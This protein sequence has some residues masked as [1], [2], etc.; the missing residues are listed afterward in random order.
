M[1]GAAGQ[2]RAREGRERQGKEEVRAERGRGKKV[3]RGSES[4]FR[5]GGLKRTISDRLWW[6]QMTL[7]RPLLAA[8]RF[9]PAPKPHSLVV[10]PYSGAPAVY[11][12]SRRKYGEIAVLNMYEDAYLEGGLRVH[13]GES[14]HPW[15]GHLFFPKGLSFNF[16]DLTHIWES[17][18]CAPK[19]RYMALVWSF[20]AN[21]LT[22]AVLLH[23]QPGFLSIDCGIAE[24]L[25]YTDDKNQMF[26]TS[27]AKFID[28][29]TNKD[30]SKDYM[31]Q[32]L[33][34]QYQNLRFFPDGT[35]N[36]YTLTPVIKS[37]RYLLRAS[38]MYG[39]Y[40]GLDQPPQF[41]AYVGVNPW[42]INLPSNSTQCV[43]N[44][45][46]MVASLDYIS[47]CL[48][49]TGHGIPFISTLELRLLNN[50]ST[51]RVGSLSQSLRLYS[52]AHFR[53]NY[54]G[55]I[56][57][58]DDA[59]DRIWYPWGQNS[60][61]QINTT[62]PINFR[63]DIGYKPPALI[64]NSGVM[65]F[66][67]DNLSFYFPTSN[68][69]PTLQYYVYMHFAEL[70]NLP[71]TQS[72]QFNFYIDGHYSF[73][74]FSPEYLSVN[75]TV[76]S[77]L[78]N[79]D[80][81]VIDLCKTTSSV[82]PPILNAM[83]IFFIQ[84]LLATPTDSKDVDAIMSIKTA[85]E[86]RRNW[87]G[88]PCVPLN[89]IWEGLNCSYPD[90]KPPTIISLDLSSSRLTGEISTLLGNL[91]S[92]QSLD[93]SNNS[94]TGPVPNFLSKLPSLKFLNL[95]N[96][97]LTGTIPTVLEERSKKGSLSLSID[98]N[99]HL[100]GSSI[101]P[102]NNNIIPCQGGSCKKRRK[103]VVHIVAPV[104]LALIML[105][106]MVYVSR[107]I[108]QRRRQR[109]GPLL[110]Q[111]QHI[112]SSEANHVV[113]AHRTASPLLFELQQITSR[114]DPVEE[115]NNT[116]DALVSEGQQII[117]TD[118]G[119]FICE[120][121]QNISAA[122]L[123]VNETGS[124]ELSEDKWVTCPEGMSYN[125]KL[126]SVQNVRSIQLPPNPRWMERWS[127]NVFDKLGS[128]CLVEEEMELQKNVPSC[129]NCLV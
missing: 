65:S 80:Q 75:T 42:D 124:T 63:E 13:V 19:E 94:L 17:C 41:G 35:R 8:A 113:E 49:N 81:H 33:P 38:F 6:L 24:D 84:Q 128:G 97:N 118:G 86:I 85:Y 121:P 107:R 9:L 90:S 122:D 76:T 52:R 88:D 26:Y 126:T 127:H 27:D 45:I 110:F 91:T 106:V 114:E 98:N 125:Q 60:W 115:T 101:G 123:V 116:G 29:G 54:D 20:L 28:T 105:I 111:H 50:N 96:N 44:E 108:N 102:V 99:P 55:Q 21:L 66:D 11:A 119:S 68:I 83:E 34:R 77:T 95:S 4:G 2:G 74:P 7:L 51:Y 58:P 61:V 40:D 79:R 62:G 100:V 70:E 112:T 82:L 120:V 5:V 57:F 46:L 73:G 12:V 18:A 14:S 87:M 48:V 47:V 89:Y 25:S 93:V 31:S 37:N 78:S 71:S 1:A 32:T 64:M 103:T 3:K 67:L 39:N 104:V 92:I 22:F 43:C 69:D 117:S 10:P 53:L 129:F 109:G 36:C 15:V 56:R 72:R 16:R 23:A 59:Y 30:I